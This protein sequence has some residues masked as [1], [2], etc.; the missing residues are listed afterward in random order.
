MKQFKLSALVIV[1]ETE[2]AVA[3]KGWCNSIFSERKTW[4]VSIW[5]PKSIIKNDI[6]PDWFMEKKFNEFY[7]NVQRVIL[8]MA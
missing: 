2:K 1:K 6:I 3:I 8:E 4:E 5:I 7:Q